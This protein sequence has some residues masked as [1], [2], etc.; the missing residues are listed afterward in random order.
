MMGF[1]Q[2]H[3][4]PPSPFLLWFRPSLAQLKSPKAESGNGG[5]GGPGPT[6]MFATYFLIY[7]VHK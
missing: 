1:I 3:V 6:A 5:P 7:Y 2:T 4:E